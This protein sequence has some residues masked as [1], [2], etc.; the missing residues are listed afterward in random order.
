[1]SQ[2]EGNGRREEGRK[3]VGDREEVERER[4]REGRHSVGREKRVVIKCKEK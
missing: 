3:G 4:E 2:R 1:M